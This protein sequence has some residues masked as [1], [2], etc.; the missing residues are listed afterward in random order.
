MTTR[1]FVSERNAA[2]RSLDK[3]KILAYAK[4]YQ[5]ELPREE[6]IFWAAVHKA[7]LEIT[8]MESAEKEVS[9]QWLKE[10]GYE[11]NFPV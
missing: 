5:I 3:E 2:L 4:K 6:E 1:S 9:R 11:L 8:A 7:R 10:H